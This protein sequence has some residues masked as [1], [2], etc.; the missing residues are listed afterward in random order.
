MKSVVKF[1]APFIGFF[2]FFG[3]LLFGIVLSSDEDQSDSVSVEV[4]GLNLSAD[5]LKHQSLVEKYCKEFGI[6]DQVKIILAIMQ[7]E[8]GGRVA[9]VMQSSESLGLP[10][11]SLSTE[12]SIKQGCKL[13]LIHI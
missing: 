9:D 12:E 8:S 6:S 11:N 4:D 5:V 13:S 2:A 7:V 10:P 1:A 3:L